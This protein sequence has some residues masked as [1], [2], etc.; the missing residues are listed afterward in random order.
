MFIELDGLS[1][2]IRNKEKMITVVLKR[3]S[4]ANGEIPEE[5][6]LRFSDFGFT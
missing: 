1:K 6:G 4:E 2:L 5:K 3:A